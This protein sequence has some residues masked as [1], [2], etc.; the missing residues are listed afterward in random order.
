M[1]AK[2]MLQNS[3][4]WYSQIINIL[5]SYTVL[6]LLIA[7]LVLQIASFLEQ[8]MVIRVSEF[9]TASQH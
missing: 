8:E 5:N 6:F 3:F 2:V 7:T 9:G 1:K 4:S